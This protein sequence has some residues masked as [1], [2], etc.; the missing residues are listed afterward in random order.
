MCNNKQFGGDGSLLRF[1]RCLAWK[2]DPYWIAS[3]YESY[4]TKPGDRHVDKNCWWNSSP[5]SGISNWYA[6]LTIVDFPAPGHPAIINNVSKSF[7]WRLLSTWNFRG[8]LFLKNMAVLRR[9]NWFWPNNNTGFS[10]FCQH[11]LANIVN[12]LWLLLRFGPRPCVAS[13]STAPVAIED[14]WRSNDSEI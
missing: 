4:S 1:L 8:L 5:N 11:R 12:R 14:A 9:P 2:I 7:S 3:E 13:S 10:L 6:D